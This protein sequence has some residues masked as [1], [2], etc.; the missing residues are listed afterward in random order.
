MSVIA[1]HII[2]TNYGTWLG[3]DP[4]GSGSRSVYTPALAALGEAHYGR[5]KT[6]PKRQVVR[7]FFQEAEAR[8]QFPIIHFRPAQFAEIAGAF[9]ETVRNRSYTCYA[10]AI[11]PD[12]VHL[13][14]RKHRDAAE[15]MIE[16]F[17][18]GSQLHLRSKGIVPVDHPVWTLNGWHV[19]LD[20][21]AAVWGRIRYVEGNPSKDGLPRQVWP[22]VV[23]YDN[24]PFHKRS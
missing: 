8:L 18:N 23:P 12:H 2:W 1:Y 24:W 13:V 6:Q 17:Q 11:L 19:F 10:C 9:A 4:R 3:N 5:R 20:S 14:I 7:E 15:E 16:N 22:F 21:T